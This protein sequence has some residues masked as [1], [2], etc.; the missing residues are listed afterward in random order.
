[1]RNVIVIGAGKIG[2]TI[3]DML[4]A[5]GDYRVAVADHSVEALAQVAQPGWRRCCS[6]SPTRL[7][8]RPRSP[9]VSRC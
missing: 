6:T 5:S 2:A 1:M 9:A 3:A 4:A 7:P 8:S